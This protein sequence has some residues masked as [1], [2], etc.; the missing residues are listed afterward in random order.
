MNST[1]SERVV[2]LNERAWRGYLKVAFDATSTSRTKLISRVM[3][4]NVA[5]RMISSGANVYFGLL[6]HIHDIMVLRNNY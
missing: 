2:F 1:L 4:S 5:R 3:T 6:G